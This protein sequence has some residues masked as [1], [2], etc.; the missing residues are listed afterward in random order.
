MS[1]RVGL[2]HKTSYKYDRLIEMGPQVV[3]LRPAV[4]CRTNVESYS[5]TVSPSDHFLNWMQ[6]PHGNYL[7][8]CVFPKKV[9]ELVVQV[10][11]VANLSVINPF[12]FFLEPDAESFPFR[13]EKEQ[14][15]DLAP[16]FQLEPV[17]EK[18]QAFVQRVDRR[19][20][21]TID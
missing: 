17:T 11:L 13:Y 16:Y 12:D 1:I 21:K 3:K 4:H 5:L 2:F 20:R 19:P 6:D 7:A 15:M 18:L 9:S 8:R 10:D 14:A